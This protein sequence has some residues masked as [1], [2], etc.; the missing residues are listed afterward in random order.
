[1]CRAPSPVVRTLAET[2]TNAVACR[3][4]VRE[5]SPNPNRTSIRHSLRVFGS[6][7]QGIGGPIRFE[8]KP[9]KTAFLPY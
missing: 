9:R 6:P 2:L 8:Q 3:G 7:G 4:R 5:V 1:M